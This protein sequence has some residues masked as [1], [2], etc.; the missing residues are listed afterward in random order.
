M[1]RYTIALYDILRRN[2]SP[3]T[4]NKDTHSDGRALFN[5]IDYLSD[6]IWENY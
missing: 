2:V 5:I 1:G 3:L 4:R 6:M